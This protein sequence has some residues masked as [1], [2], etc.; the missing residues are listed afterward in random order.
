ML[1]SRAKAAKILT[2]VLQN[3]KSLREAM[4]A[5]KPDPFAQELCYGVL[6]HYFRL[7]F[8]I[9]ELTQ[10]PIKDSDIKAL[11][12]IGLYQLFCLQ[13]PPHAAV[14]ETVEAARQLKKGWATSLINGVLRNALRSQ[15]KLEEKI[16]AHL[17][18]YYAHPL[19]LIQKLQNAFP[20]DW[21]NILEQNNQHP[22][23]TLR[24]NTARLSREDYLQALKTQNIEAIATAISPYGIQLKKPLPINNL[25]GFAEGL[26]SVQD[27]AAQLAAPLL[28]LSGGQVVLDACAAPGGKTTHLLEIEHRLKQ[29]VAVES[30][31]ERLP[32][33]QSNLTRLKLSAELFGETIQHFAKRWEPSYFDRILLDV[34]CSATGVIRRHPDIKLLRKNSDITPLAKEQ[35]EILTAVWPLLKR[36]GI[37]LYVTCSVLIEENAAVLEQFLQNTV[38]AKEEIITA[39]WGKAMPVGRQI[40][41]GDMDGFYFAKLIKV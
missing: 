11:L 5:L 18:A 21:K 30:E 7:D 2:A 36:G 19:W 24:L 28:D 38:D 6:R 9:E 22:P 40:L 34:P 31:P 10:H 8:Y 12:L 1:H 16:H 37:L 32:L 15:K 13:K 4:P 25:Y 41:P 29:L 35:Y 26:I 17:S 39:S 3:K 23:M 27:E 14:T 20:A 33:I